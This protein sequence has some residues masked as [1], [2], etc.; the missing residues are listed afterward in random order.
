MTFSPNDAS[1]LYTKATVL[2]HLGRYEEALSAAD[3]SLNLSFPSPH[4][5]YER[6]I[7]LAVLKRH[8]EASTSY[9]EYLAHAPND[10][11]ALIGKGLTLQQ[12]GQLDEAYDFLCRAWKLKDRLAEEWVKCIQQTLREIGRGTDECEDV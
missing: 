11:L 4:A 5:W 3:A 12:L 7:L 8:D 10:P 9:D 2:R 6:G 1:T